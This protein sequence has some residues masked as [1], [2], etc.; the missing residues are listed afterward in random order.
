M[1]LTKREKEQVKPMLSEILYAEHQ[2]DV[3]RA[4][5]RLAPALGLPQPIYNQS[6]ALY[7]EHVDIWP[8][9]KFEGEDE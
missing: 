5:Y 4:L 6:E 2:G 1:P 8:W 9:D 7:S 3:N